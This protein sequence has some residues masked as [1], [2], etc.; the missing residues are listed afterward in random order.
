MV[1]T[2]PPAT[3]LRRAESRSDITADPSGRNTVDQGSCRPSILVRT[4]G[5]AGSLE[6]VPPGL[7]DALP[8]VPV[9]LPAVPEDGVPVLPAVGAVPPSPVHPA[10]MRAKTKAATAAR[11]EGPGRSEPGA[12]LPGAAEPCA[13][14]WPAP[15]LLTLLPPSLLFRRGGGARHHCPSSLHCPF[16]RRQP[17]PLSGVTCAV[18]GSRQPRHAPP[19]GTILRPGLPHSRS[20]PRRSR[21][22][23][24]HRP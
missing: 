14:A 18:R 5:A 16:D 17:R 24:W 6:T 10:S 7:A 15:V 11:A 13:L 12:R 19:S 9:P 20:C 3:D 23:S 21:S 1:R 4:T 8:P 22:S 2:C